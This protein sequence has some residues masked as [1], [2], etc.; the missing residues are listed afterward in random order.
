MVALAADKT[1][2]TFG[3]YAV[4]IIGDDGNGEFISS[5]RTAPGVT[6]GQNSR[7]CLEINKNPEYKDGWYYEPDGS[8]NGLTKEW[9]EKLKIVQELPFPIP[10]LPEGYAWADGFPQFRE[11]KK[12]EYYVNKSYHNYP[13]LYT[14]HGVEIV[15]YK[16]K[17]F[18]P[19][20]LCSEFGAK[21]FAVVKATTP[22]PETTN[23][24]DPLIAKYGE[25]EA[26]WRWLADDEKVEEGDECT[27]PYNE[28]FELSGNYYSAHS[29]H[30]TPDCKPYRRKIMTQSQQL[31]DPIITDSPQEAQVGEWVECIDNSDY[32]HKLTVGKKYR[33]QK[34]TETTCGERFYQLISDN[35]RCISGW[36]VCRFKKASPEKE[37]VV[38]TEKDYPL[39]YKH[40]NDGFANSV[41][42]LV[43]ISNYVQDEVIYKNG[44]SG[45]KIYGC[46]DWDSACETYVK[47]GLWIQV[48]ESE[49]LDFI[50]STYRQKIEEEK[51][52]VAAKLKFPLYYQHKGG[53]NGD[54]KY[55]KRI[56]ESQYT[57]ILKK[58][59]KEVENEMYKWDKQRDQTVAEGTWVEVPEAEVNRFIASFKGPEEKETV[60][61]KLN[62]PIYYQ[63]A[64]KTGF[65][66]G[67][68]YVKR[69]SEN[70]FNLIRN[71]G[72]IDKF[73]YLWEYTH[74]GIVNKGE[75]WIEV[76]ESEV[77]DF[78]ASVTV[79]EANST[80]VKKEEE[81][82]MKKETLVKAATS[83]ARFAGNWGFKLV[84]YFFLETAANIARPILRGA[85]YAVFLGSLSAAVYGYNHPEVVKNA[86]KS[87]IPKITI[88]APE[89][90]KG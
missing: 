37:V 52:A 43:R 48:P 9:T 10:K 15:E 14:K 19:S 73:Q 31:G 47:N 76:P 39:Y 53:F 56:N 40:R 72:K 84:N 4:E 51:E 87:C 35:D 6:Y 12:G 45:K 70:C 69:I 74:D 60:A 85:R 90:L 79:T 86:I 62:F 64:T 33:I 41:K 55:I 67:I 68:K 27:N 2:L 29:K 36:K 16:N 78:I 1:Y 83:S 22:T 32:K 88:E 42:Y 30:Q 18:E 58:D 11:I 82:E 3:G 7:T 21:R 17:H 75:A 38:E 65:I 80:L 13:Q 26:G 49:V 71:N 77:L 63:H 57:V 5:E 34:Q 24:V 66:G 25:P 50:A 46:S 28:K 8:V 59:G 44:K 20:K 61:G 89:V 23:N 81:I 54:T